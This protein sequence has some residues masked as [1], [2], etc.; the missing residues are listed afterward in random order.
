LFNK[1]LKWLD[2]NFE[3]TVM[4]VLFYT[5]TFLIT[6]QVILRFVFSTG[7][8]WGEEVA[9]FLFVW[10]MNFSI[11][12][13]TRNQRHIRISFF[14]NLFNDKV[15]RV[16]LILSD[17][18]FLLFSTLIFY[19]AIRV[20]QAAIKYADMAVTI[21]V[22]LNIVYGAGVLGYAL[23]LIRL[24]QSILWKFKYFNSDF[25]Q[26]ENLGGKYNSAD[27]IFF[28]IPTITEDTEKMAEGED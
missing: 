18:I 2:I 8:S 19:A 6:L 14:I 17:F 24:I 23:I 22:S 26:F 10:L 7:F 27:K 28:M 21:E 12:Y 1:V 20:C 15:R 9:R 11:S 5:I 16:F 25:D 4:A 3:P 13:A